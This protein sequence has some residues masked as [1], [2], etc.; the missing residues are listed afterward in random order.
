MIIFALLLAQ[1]FQDFFFAVTISYKTVPALVPLNIISIS[2][3]PGREYFDASLTKANLG[4]IGVGGANAANCFF[5][6]SLSYAGA[7]V[8]HQNL[9]ACPG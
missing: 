9:V 3:L 4:R 1:I 6:G 8:Q 5:I 7:K 2:F